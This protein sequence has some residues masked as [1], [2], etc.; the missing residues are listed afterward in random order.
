MRIGELSTRSGLSAASIKFY[1]REGLLHPAER[2]GYNQ[3]DY[4]ESH[5]R[6]LRLIRSLIDVG[7]LRLEAAKRVLAA[8][9][10]PDLPIAEL[11]GTAHNAAPSPETE[12]S[13]E[14]REAI[15]SVAERFGWVHSPT[16]PGIVL[17]AS[18]LDAYR[19]LGL[20]ELEQ[21]LQ[22]YAEAADR[23]AQSEVALALAAPNTA[24][25]AE[26]VAVGTVLGDSLLAGL[27]RVAQE[28]VAMGTAVDR[29][30]IPPPDPDDP[31]S[32]AEVG[33][34]AAI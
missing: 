2:T 26:I 18:V 8:A 22:P 1:V 17:A 19:D 23:V 32:G 12:P 33:V 16:N 15:R 27:R 9:D 5:V 13:S 31:S 4:D 11:L 24:R 21:L 14:S 3:S 29:G 34:Q 20:T 25:I 30:L 6:R 7:G 28:S 10:D